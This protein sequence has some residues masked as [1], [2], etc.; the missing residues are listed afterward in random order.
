M[1]EDILKELLSIFAGEDVQ[2]ET[3]V[4]INGNEL[5]LFLKKEGNDII[6][7]L[8]LQEDEFKKFVNSL[9]EDIFIEACERY[10]EITGADLSDNVDEDS[11]K[12]VVNQVIKGKISRLQKFIK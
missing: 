12:A 4:N 9:D 8:S 3:E 7:R 6:L 2:E 10:K 1:N 5:K 11:F